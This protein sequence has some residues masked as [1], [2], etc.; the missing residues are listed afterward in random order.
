MNDKYFFKIILLGPSAT[1]AKSSLMIRMV[2]NNFYESIVPTIGVEFK[3]LNVLTENGTAKLQIW[4]TA[5]QSNFKKITSSYYKGCHCFVL[6]YD[7][8]D[9]ESFKLIKNDF[10]NSIF[11]NLKG[12]QVKNPL[13][14]LVA[15][16]IDLQD[17]IEVTDEEAISFANEKKIPFFKVS[18]K[19]GE[20][21]NFLKIDIV[22]SL[23][24]QFPK[25]K[26]K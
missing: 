2:E 1:G 14:Y 4:D 24:K 7:I 12:N 9:K 23:I 21:V 22:K 10:F 8:T 6:G 16:K 3:I 26:I 5:G 15:N 13:I 20:G 19:T 25:S 18:A 17:R 11:K